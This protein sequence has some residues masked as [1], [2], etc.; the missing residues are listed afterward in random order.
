MSAINSIES[1]EDERRRQTSDGLVCLSE[2][3]A[4]AFVARRYRVNTAAFMFGALE[5]AR[6]TD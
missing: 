2:T 5:S 1:Y 6:P 4:R 3:A